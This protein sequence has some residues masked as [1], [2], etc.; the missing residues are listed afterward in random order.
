M[1]ATTPHVSYRFIQYFLLLLTEG[2]AEPPSAP[3]GES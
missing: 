3:G 2:Y 1:S